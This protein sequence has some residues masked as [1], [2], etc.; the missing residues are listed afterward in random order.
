VL[1]VTVHDIYEK[2]PAF[3]F[4]TTSFLLFLLPSQDSHTL[5]VADSCYVAILR[6]LFATALL[7]LHA[8]LLEPLLS[9]SRR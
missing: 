5:M 8:Y 1:A 3:V 7:L 6:T 4:M 9:N 2:E